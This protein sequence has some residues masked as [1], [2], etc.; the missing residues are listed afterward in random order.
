MVWRQHPPFFRYKS[1]SHLRSRSKWGMQPKKHKY[2]RCARNHCPTAMFED[3]Q[4][5]MCVC[6]Y[7]CL[8]TIAMLCNCNIC[9]EWMS[10]I[11]TL[12]DHVYCILSNERGKRQPCKHRPKNKNKKTNVGNQLVL[13]GLILLKIEGHKNNVIN[14]DFGLNSQFWLTNML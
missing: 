7:S 14:L 1:C 12:D 10:T 2:S 4:S 5:W 6:W 3:G 9:N 8:C 13:A 11:I